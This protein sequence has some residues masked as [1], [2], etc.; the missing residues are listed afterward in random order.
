MIRVG[1]YAGTLRERVLAYKFG[2][3][4]RLDA[5]LAQ[6][7]SDALLGRGGVAEVDAFVPIPT[8]TRGGIGRSYD[9]VAQLARLIG[10]RLRRPCLRVLAKRRGVR[11]QVGLSP[12]ERWT[13]I[14]G[15][16][17]V[18]RGAR[19]AGTTLCL[20]DDVSTTGATLD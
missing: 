13:N 11:S 16:L 20:I 10:R 1:P 18:R 4:V 19:L 12:T 5:A 15:A 6:L 8:R 14:R 3:Q 9:P 7:V 2:F 17:R